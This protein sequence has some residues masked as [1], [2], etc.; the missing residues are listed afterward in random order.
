MGYT[1]GEDLLCQC[2]DQKNIPTYTKMTTEQKIEAIKEAIEKAKN[3]QSKMDETAWS[4]PALSSLKIRHLMNNLGFISTRYL[5][6]GVHVSGLFSSTIRNNSNLI[7]ATANDS[8]ASDETGDIKYEPQFYANMQKCISPNTEF[9]MLKGDTFHMEPM[10][11]LGPI[12][13]YLYDAHH[14]YEAE[15]RAVTHFL[16]AMAD[17]FIMCK[18]DWQYSDVKRATIDG[19]EDSGCEILF[20][21]ELLNP[22]PYTEDQHLNM[23]YWRGFAV[24]LLKKK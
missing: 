4:V 5:E 15:R 19:L 6:C 21:E 20:Q 1:Y 2:H 12:D 7:S 10:D 3:H 8:F 14:S 17:T 9:K 23:M 13:L 24:F 18:D 11:V 16:P 22:E